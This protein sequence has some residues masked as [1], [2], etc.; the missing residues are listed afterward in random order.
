MDHKDYFPR[1]Q[2]N[3]KLT[4]SVRFKPPSYKVLE[5]ELLGILSKLEHRAEILTAISHGQRISG[6]YELAEAYRK[7][8]INSKAKAQSIRKLLELA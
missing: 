2:A 7:Q 4:S 1:A 3:K 5:N 6:C 8:S